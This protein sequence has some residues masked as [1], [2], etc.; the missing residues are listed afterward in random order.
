M[1]LRL[2]RG[3]RRFEPCAQGEH[4][5]SRG[6]LPA[7]TWSAHWIADGRFRGPIAAFLAREER[8]VCRYMEELNGHS[9]FRRE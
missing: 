8:G 1:D 9:P 3:L 4:K 5:I 7:A 2:E 6:F